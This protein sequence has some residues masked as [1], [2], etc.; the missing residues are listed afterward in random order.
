MT[1]LNYLYKLWSELS[2]GNVV[3]GYNNVLDKE[4][5]VRRQYRVHKEIVDACR[6]GDSQKICKVVSDHYMRT[7]TR[8]MKEQGV[9][10]DE[11]PFPR[12][13]LL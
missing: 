7:I 3:T 12:D 11:V 13:F 5:V 2:Y 10:E 8:L 1:G 9:A 6:T 4:R